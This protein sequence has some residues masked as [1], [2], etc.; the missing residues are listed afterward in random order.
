MPAI[1]QRGPQPHPLSAVF[2]PFD[3]T[4]F[5][6]FHSIF[7]EILLTKVLTGS[8]FI[9][10]ENISGK[11][12]FSAFFRIEESA[13]PLSPL[14][15]SFHP[16]PSPPFSCSF[17]LPSPFFLLPFLFSFSPLSNRKQL[18]DITDDDLQPH[19]HFLS[20]IY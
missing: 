7:M 16:P 1:F 20:Q 2:Y 18:L 13:L 8:F 12:H 6:G 10:E 9:N 17:T 11:S 14:I 4:W 19:I 5:C 3:C 15:L